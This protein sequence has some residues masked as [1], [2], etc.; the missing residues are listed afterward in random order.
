MLWALIPM[1]GV[2]GLWL[3]GP[4]VDG[5]TNSTGR[6]RTPVVEDGAGR[7]GMQTVSARVSEVRQKRLEVAPVSRSPS[8]RAAPQRVLV[9]EPKNTLDRGELAAGRNT[10]TTAGSSSG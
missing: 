5:W 3:T 6:A 4:V 2:A 10:P 1:G 7:F 8:Y 9:R